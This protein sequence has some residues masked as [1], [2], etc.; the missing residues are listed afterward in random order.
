MENDTGIPAQAFMQQ[1]IS[2]IHRMNPHG[3]LLQKD[4]SETA[5]RG[6][7]IRCDPPMDRKP[8]MLQGTPQFGGATADILMREFDSQLQIGRNHLAAFQQAL[9]FVEDMSGGDIS[10]CPGA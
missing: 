1:P 6:S 4:L 8:E 10:L 5:C 2:N 9:G 3:T 7:Q